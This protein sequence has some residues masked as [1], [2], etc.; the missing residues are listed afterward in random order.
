MFGEGQRL[1]KAVLCPK[2]SLIDAYIF[3]DNIKSFEFYRHSTF[4]FFILAEDFIVSIKMALTAGVK[5]STLLY[6]TH[7]RNLKNL[8]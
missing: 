3:C 1:T 4:I 7:K 2:Q 8:T 5:W 6:S